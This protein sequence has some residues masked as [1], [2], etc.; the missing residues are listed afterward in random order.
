[1]VL[2]VF[3]YEDFKNGVNF[4][5]FDFSPFF[6]KIKIL[7]F[8]SKIQFLIKISESLSTFLNY[9]CLYLKK[10]KSVKNSSRNSAKTSKSPKGEINFR[11]PL[12]NLLQQIIRR[13]HFLRLLILILNFYGGQCWCQLSSYYITR[14]CSFGGPFKCS[15]LTTSTYISCPLYIPFVKAC[16]LHITTRC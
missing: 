9:E 14:R 16:Q 7:T 3:W 12:K 15:T 4:F 8:F 13:H 2:Y 10:T 5:Y 1:M 11:A 6:G